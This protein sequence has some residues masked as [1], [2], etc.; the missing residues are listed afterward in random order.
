VIENWKAH[1]EQ[2]YTPIASGG[3]KRSWSGSRKDFN[4]FWLIKGQLIDFIL[5]HDQVNYLRLFFQLP[6]E[7]TLKMT[8]NNKKYQS[9]SEN[10]TNLLRIES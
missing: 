3:S 9:N 6:Q 4:L 7:L 2:M 10:Y 5:I 1:Y 8:H